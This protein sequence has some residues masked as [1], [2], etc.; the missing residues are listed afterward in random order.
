MQSTS[1]E[2]SESLQTNRLVSTDGKTYKHDEHYLLYASYY[3]LSDETQVH[4]RKSYTIVALLAEFGGL[5]AIVSKAFGIIGLFLNSRDQMSN[6]LNEMYYLKLSTKQKGFAG[7]WK[8]HKKF[9]D[10]LHEL[11]FSNKD[12][13]CEIKE[14]FFKVFCCTPKVD[15]HMSRT[16]KF[17]IKGLH[18]I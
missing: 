8:N 2:S 17:F 7:M 11:T 10:N 13:L 12:M 14:T 9:T 3:F 5:F 16:E 4:T 18:K 6:L 15:I 1:W